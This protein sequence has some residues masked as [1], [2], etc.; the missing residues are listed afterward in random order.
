MDKLK[1]ECSTLTGVEGSRVENKVTPD[2]DQDRDL[3]D[4]IPFKELTA[5]ELKAL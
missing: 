4:L 5:K 1:A 2:P 3:E